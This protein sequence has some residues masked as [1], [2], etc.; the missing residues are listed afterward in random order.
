MTAIATDFYD[1]L[2][3]AAPELRDLSTHD[4]AAQQGKVAADLQTILLTIR[5]HGDFLGRAGALGAR[6]AGY[7]VHAA[8]YRTVGDSPLAA[9]GATLGP[10]WTEEV[11][12]GWRSA[13][14]LTAEVIMA[15]AAD[16]E[17]VPGTSVAAHMRRRRATRLPES[18][19]GGSWKATCDCGTAQ[20]RAFMSWHRIDVQV[21]G[22]SWRGAGD[23]AVDHC[24][25]AT[26][27]GA[28]RLPISRS[29]PDRPD[30]WRRHVHR[31]QS[32]P[33]PSIV[34]THGSWRRLRPGAD[35]SGPIGEHLVAIG[36]TGSA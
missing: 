27:R 31:A 16:V 36:A 5:E 3:A 4:L 18:C 26:G 32:P 8:H 33:A 17:E 20:I 2:S 10:A 28:E 1:R 29:A 30:T 11:A 24:Y 13:Y 19:V 15:G 6:H 14:H 12:G 25:R 23:Y 22:D 9:M 7:G 35:T 21:S 34:V